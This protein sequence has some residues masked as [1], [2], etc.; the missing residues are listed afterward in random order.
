MQITVLLFSD[1][2]DALDTDRLEVELE[3]GVDVDSALSALA[4]AYPPI[5]QRQATLA[6]AVNEHYAQG[7]RELHH[8]DTLALISPVSGG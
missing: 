7:T 2:A 5:Q 8:G 1:L 4:E 3:E 6:I